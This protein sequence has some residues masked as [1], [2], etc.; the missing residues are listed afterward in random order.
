MKI[1]YINMKILY[2]YVYFTPNLNLPVFLFC[3]I[4]NENVSFCIK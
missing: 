4:N 2:F 3:M 1:I